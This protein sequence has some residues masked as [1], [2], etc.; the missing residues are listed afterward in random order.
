MRTR[1]LIVGGGLAGMTLANALGAA[2]VDT[3]IVDRDP[4]ETR[5]A[6]AFDG[7]TTAIAHASKRMMEAIGV[8]AAVEDDASPITDIRIAD[9][10]APVFL[11]YD[12]RE[13]GVDPFGHIVE[14]RLLRLAQAARLEALPAVTMLNGT[15]VKDLTFGPG[16]ATATLDDG[17]T[18]R[19][20]LVVGADGRGSFVR[21]TAG[22]D[23]FSW[24]YRQKAIACTMQ[25]ERPHQGVAVEHFMPA[26]PFAVLPMTDDA[27]GTPRSSIVWT[28]R[29]DRADGVAALPEPDFDHELQNRVGEYLGRV[30]HVGG[31]WVYPLGVIHAERYIGPRLALIS[32]AAHGIHPIAGQGLNMGLRDVAALAEII[33]DAAR[34]GLD[35]G[36]GEGLGRYQ[37]WRRFDNI[38]LVAVTDGLNRLF[39]NSIPPV[40]MARD[41]GLAIVGR[42]APLKRVFMRHAMG[43]MG[44]LPRLLRGTPL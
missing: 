8:W 10:H 7:R 21:R 13:V 17:R 1:V 40:R 26:G 29:A 4:I 3:V 32:E 31:R 34:A 42:V 9:D 35:V 16:L 39:S 18:I 43:T 11:H 38:T 28:E 27:D 30:R 44:E 37:R 22:I 36:D 12:H 41:A 25:H 19:A 14:N 5:T 6:G 2:G 33:V 15:A 23:T 20:E 24:K